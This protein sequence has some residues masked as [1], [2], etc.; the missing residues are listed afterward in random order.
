MNLQSIFGVEHALDRLKPVEVLSTPEIVLPFSLKVVRLRKVRTSRADPGLQGCHR[1]FH[2][3]GLFPSQLNV[4]GKS[5]D[6][7]IGRRTLCAA[8]A[9]AKLSATTG[10]MTVSSTTARRTAQP[11]IRVKC[12][13]PM[14]GRVKQ[15]SNQSVTP[16]GFQ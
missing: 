3:L 11:L 5:S 13:G 2:P 9:S 1:Q 7:R 6:T 12:D 4:G 10:L 15:S 16:C 14:P 8:K